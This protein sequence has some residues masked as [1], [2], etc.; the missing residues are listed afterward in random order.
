VVAPL[1]ALVQQ[2]LQLLQRARKLCLIRCQSTKTR[3]P[4][5]K[6]AY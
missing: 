5:V 4:L 3:Q 2:L 1:G 6:Q